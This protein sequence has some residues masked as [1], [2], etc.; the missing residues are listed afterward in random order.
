M[1]ADESI[2]IASSHGLPEK[3]PAQ[4][5][6]T[7]EKISIQTTST[8]TQTDFLDLGDQEFKPTN[9]FRHYWLDVNLFA[10]IPGYIY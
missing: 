4:P 6:S 9:H 2:A 7:P 1:D 3:Q 10:A 8:I 5:E